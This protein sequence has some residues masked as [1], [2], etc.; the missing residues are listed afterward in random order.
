MM[1][2]FRKYNKHLLA[3]FMALLLVIWLGGDA[4]QAFVTPDPGKRV[5]GS[6]IGGKVTE[7]DRALAERETQLLNHL[8]Q[9]A[10]SS[11][12]RAS[13]MWQLWQ[14][15]L[16]QYDPPTA[17]ERLGYIEWVLLKREAQRMGVAVTPTQ[18]KS[19]LAS[20]G[21]SEDV[22]RQMAVRSNRIPDTYFEA[23]ASYYSVRNMVDLAAAVT[24][25]PEPELRRKA[26]DIMERATIEAVV[27]PAISF[28]DPAQTFSPEQMQ[29]Q[30]DAHRTARAGNGLNFGYYQEPQVR[31]QYIRIAPAELEPHLRGSA[32]T[33]EREAYEYWQENRETKSEFRFSLAEV[34]QL[35]KQQA[36]A[37][38]NGLDAG[39]NGVTIPAAGSFYTTFAQAREK[40]LKLVRQQ[41]AES[42]AD[43]IA[44]RLGQALREP[45]FATVY[46]ET[47]HRPAP[48]AV[49]TEEHYAQTLAA[50]PAN[51][52][53]PAGVEAKTLD[54]MTSAQ[55][56]Q[57]GGF[58]DASVPIDEQRALPISQLAFD[59]QG[60]ADA[61]EEGRRDTSLHL[62]LWQT[63]SK[64]VLA[65][66]GTIYLF[67]V[68]G[69]KEGHAP[70]SLAEVSDQVVEDLRLLEGMDAART[71]AGSFVSNVSTGG[72]REAWMADEELRARVTPDRGG[73]VEPPPFP[74]DNSLIGARG[75]VVQPFGEVTK[76]FIE[77]A[78][79]LAA[80]GQ[81]NSPVEI[82]DLPD[83]AR[84]VAMRGLAKSP[85][86]EEDFHERRDFLTQHFSRQK[87]SEILGQW[88]NAKMVRKRAEF[89]MAGRL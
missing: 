27:F 21:L 7:A 36:E 61:P 63:F 10:T 5:I 57:I 60:L 17:D 53:Y 25:P 40:A 62:S 85:L 14:D 38:S 46:D 12:K 56:A 49:K 15:A 22:V 18:A 82:V 47:G 41:T 33:F 74:R 59:V 26:R 3:I 11:N 29:K 16:Q 89:E 83:E 28:A 73:Y 9:V 64:P 77:T 81:D 44:N 67:R 37:S 68:I 52:Q 76:E 66:D 32:Q 86:Y 30:F 35:K 55:L 2:F 50:L 8:T 6:A 79:R 24:V 75:N 42:E 72:L 70:E 31:V 80:E 71:A 23:A 65:E 13:F 78:F 1:K 54:W 45:W 87:Q 4:I 20:E 58:G 84:V 69:V 88:L 43:R 51:M 48:D 19:I 39:S 34:E